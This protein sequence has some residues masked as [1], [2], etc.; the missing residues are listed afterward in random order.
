[1]PRRL[2]NRLTRASFLVPG[3]LSLSPTPLSLLSISTLLLRLSISVS[4]AMASFC[5]L[6][7]LLLGVSKEAH[8]FF[9]SSPLNICLE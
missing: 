5:S 2:V 6:S 1:M 8:F 9:S 7:I 4:S 3:P